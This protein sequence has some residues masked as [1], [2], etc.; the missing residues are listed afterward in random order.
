[1]VLTGLETVVHALGYV[2]QITM[3]SEEPI[4][5]LLL[6]NRA[7]EQMDKPTPEPG[8]DVRCAVVSV[9]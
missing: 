3:C 2:V 5:N 8:W 6:D 7:I 4:V 1:M 9:I